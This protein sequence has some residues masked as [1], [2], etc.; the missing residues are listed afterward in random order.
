MQLHH[1][2]A[3]VL[4]GGDES[5]FPRILAIHDVWPLLHQ[6]FFQPLPVQPA[7]PQIAEHLRRKPLPVIFRIVDPEIH[8]P[9]PLRHRIKQIPAHLVSRNHQNLPVGMLLKPGNLIDQHPLHPAGIGQGVGGQQEFHIFRPSAVERTGK[10]RIP[11]ICRRI[12]CT[13]R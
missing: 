1:L 7:S 4:E 2:A 6:Q 3:S 12:P 11:G 10:W 9:D 5:A 13:T 8:N